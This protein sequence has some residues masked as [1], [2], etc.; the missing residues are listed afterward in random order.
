MKPR[1]ERFLLIFSVALNVAFVATAA[2]THR[3]SSSS[4]P[5]DVT[6]PAR[7]SSHWHGHRTDAMDRRL[8]LER[9]QRRVLRQQLG[10][11]RPELEATRRDLA[12]ARQR[13]R[14]ALRR[15]D[16]PGVRAARQQ[17]S[18]VQTRLDSLTAEA[19]LAEI[20]VLHPEQRERY[21]RWTF[22]RRRTRL[23]RQRPVPADEP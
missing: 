11:F 23:P 15:D 1:A 12:A 16:A 9:H 3:H 13:F 10:D 18:R 22:E 6:E 2:V 21:V 5:V 4:Q 20:N 7:F 17:V 14:E 19:M 8:H